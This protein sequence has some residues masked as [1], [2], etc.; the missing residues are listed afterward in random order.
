LGVLQKIRFIIIEVTI[1]QE[2]SYFVFCGKTIERED[3]RVT[4]LG[5]GRVLDDLK[6]GLISSPFQ[7]VRPMIENVFETDDLDKRK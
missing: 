3:R 2:D 4:K 7:A 6:E 5:K 1:L